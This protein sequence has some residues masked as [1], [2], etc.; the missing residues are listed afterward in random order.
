VVVWFITGIG[1][2]LFSQSSIEVLWRSWSNGYDS[3]LWSEA[4][5][6]SFSKMELLDKG[7]QSSPSLR[8]TSFYEGKAPAK[9]SFGKKTE[10]NAESLK[11]EFNS[12]RPPIFDFRGDE[13]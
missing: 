12:R 4:F 3:G 7:E 2:D 8:S 9:Q 1:K 11:P 10:K 5:R 6:K 13:K